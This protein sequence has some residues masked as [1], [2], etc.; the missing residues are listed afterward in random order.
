LPLLALNFSWIK[1]L[2]DLAQDT[3]YGIKLYT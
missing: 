3:I 2:W 1:W